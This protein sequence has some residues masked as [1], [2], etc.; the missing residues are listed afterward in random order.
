MSGVKHLRTRGLVL[1]DILFG[2]VAIAVMISVFT[3]VSIRQDDAMQKLSEQRE[4]YRT[5][6]S[7]LLHMQNRTP[8]DLPVT[9]NK[10]PDPS[11]LVGYVWVS[12]LHRDHEGLEPLVGLVPATEVTR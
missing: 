10:L 6:E 8:I 3:S 1:Y 7:A 11:P 5:C 2:V 4:V 9:V 12:V